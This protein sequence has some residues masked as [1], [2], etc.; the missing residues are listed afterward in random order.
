M[1]IFKVIVTYPNAEVEELNQEFFTLE[2]AIFGAKHIL[3]QVQ[4]NAQ[5]HANR[6]AKVKPFAIVKE[7]SG[8]EA[9]IVYDS[10]K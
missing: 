4:Y 1:S 6:G 5:F 8:Q 2:E 7:I 3:G 10:R 9:K